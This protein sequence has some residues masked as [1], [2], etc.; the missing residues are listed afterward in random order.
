MTDTPWTNT[1]TPSTRWVAQPPKIAPPPQAKGH[2]ASEASP[3]LSLLPWPARRPMNITIKYRGGPE[4]WY[5]IR[6]RNRT[7]RVPG[8]VC[9]HDALKVLWGGTIH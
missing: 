1:G 4:C 7:M 6:A 3:A 8:V 5:E 2:R 9:I